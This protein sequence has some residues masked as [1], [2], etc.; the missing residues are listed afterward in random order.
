MND[1]IRSS[2]SR[3]L[4][5]VPVV[6]AGL[7]PVRFLGRGQDIAVEVQAAVGTVHRD[8]VVAIHLAIDQCIARV[9]APS[10]EPVE[11]P[12]PFRFRQP[13]QPCPRVRQDDA[14]KSVR[15]IAR[16]PFACLSCHQRSLPPRTPATQIHATASLGESSPPRL[17]CIVG[18][19]TNYMAVALGGPTARR[20][21]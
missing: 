19:V 9:G 17:P 6:L 15:G 10:A 7:L 12:V 4:Y 8:R 20:A 5:K 21:A 18:N 14:H 11:G 2:R 1:S 13:T 16:I 3:I